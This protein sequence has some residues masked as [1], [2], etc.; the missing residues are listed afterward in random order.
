MKMRRACAWALMFLMVFSLVMGSVSLEARANGPGTT[1]KFNIT[2][3]SGFANGNMVS[4]KLYNGSSWDGGWTTAS[5]G[6]NVDITGATKI[7][8]VV[9][10]ADAN[11]VSVTVTEINGNLSGFDSAQLANTTE[12]QEFDLAA[13]TSYELNI[14]FAS[15]GP[16]PGPITT[17]EDITVN[18]SYP[19]SGD[20]AWM[21][22]IQ[23]DGTRVQNGTVTVE[24]A[25][26]HEI[27]LQCAFGFTFGAIS[28]NGT[29]MPLNGSDQVAYTVD[30]AA[31]YNIVIL[32]GNGIRTIAW[33]NEGSLGSDAKVE[34][35]KVQIIAASGMTDMTEDPA[36][37]GLYAIMPGTVVTIKLIPDY[38]YQLKGTYLN[39]IT[40]AAGAEV[41]S[42]T[43]TM[44]DTNLHLESI[45]EKTED[46][47]DCADSKLV[48][49]ASIANGANAASSGNLSLT[50]EDNANYNTN[51]LSAVSGTGVSKVASVD[52]TLD[53]IVGKGDGTYWESNI[54][55]FQ[56]DITV[57][58][59]LDAGALEAGQTY[60]VVRDHNG[61]LTELSATY[62]AATGTLTFPSNQ[63]S[64]YT[65][66]K[67]DGTATGNGASQNGSG[68]N[69][70]DNVP[71]TGNDHLAEMWFALALVSG[72]GLLAVNRKKCVKG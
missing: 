21:E 60:S 59:T 52:I 57:S 27:E 43:F 14:T 68:A 65:I 49:K 40:V 51:A 6:G 12:G 66:V 41:S 29:V 13:D 67:K 63:F 56:K 9:E 30:D 7:K 15:G 44:P 5:N 47:I 20:S 72:A 3:S 54:T 62:D 8:L 28:I 39:G 48:S 37:G 1:M 71:K 22:N 26:R 35:G 33:D 61:T 70:K 16:T 23:I 31:V 69:V 50:V 53:N 42:F 38:G 2:N 18:V 34:N 45:F 10:P 55:E 58:L 4:Y 36:L 11:E 64:T 46:K 19:N 17:P 32:L 24:R 25:D